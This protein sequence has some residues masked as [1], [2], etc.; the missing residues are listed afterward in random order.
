[1]P[2]RSALD[3]RVLLTGGSIVRSIIQRCDIN[4]RWL[5][6]EEA[7]FVIIDTHQHFW[8][9]DQPRGS[10]PDDYR[11][12]TAAEG[13]T[14]TILRL[15]EKEGA[16]ALAETEPLIVGV[17]GAIERGPGFASELEKLSA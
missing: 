6:A 5:K 16:L 8:N 9:V 13:V 7:R 11:I 10:T 12:L 2:R 15:S 14:G 3:V 1:M 4:S 17:C